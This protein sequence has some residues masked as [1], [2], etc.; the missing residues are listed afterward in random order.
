MMAGDGGMAGAA[1]GMVACAPMVLGSELAFRMLVRRHGVTHTYSPMVKADRLVGGAS[2]EQRILQD[3]SSEDRPLALQ[4]C[5]RD[6]AVLAKLPPS[7]T[8]WQQKTWSEGWARHP[9]KYALGVVVPFEEAT[10]LIW[11]MRSGASL[12]KAG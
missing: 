1:G 8:A 2:E 9:T 3:T 11:L 5:G 4:L 12:L 6:P 7:V 10:R